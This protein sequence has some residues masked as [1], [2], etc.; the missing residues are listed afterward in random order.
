MTAYTCSK[1]SHQWEARKI[2]KPVSCPRCK[3]YKWEKTVEGGRLTP[4]AVKRIEGE[5]LKLAQKSG[6]PLKMPKEEERE[7]VPFDDV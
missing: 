2:G 6:N 7:I 5:G 3:S 1:C 4:E